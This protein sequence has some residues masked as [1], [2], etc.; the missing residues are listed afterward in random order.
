MKKEECEVKEGQKSY[1]GPLNLQIKPS[2]ALKFEMMP[3][4]ATRSMTYLQFQATRCPLS[5]MYFSPSW[6]C[7]HHM[8][9]I[10]QSVCSC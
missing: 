3:P 8:D 1:P 4:L 9:R 7:I 6:S 5:I 10:S 2:P